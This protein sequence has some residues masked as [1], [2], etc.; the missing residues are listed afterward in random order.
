VCG[1]G[2]PEGTEACD[3]G[4][5]T[6]GD[7]C[8][9][10]CTVTACGNGV[11][12]GTEACDDGNTT[13]G[14]GCDNN[15]TAS[16]CGN[17]ISA[18]TEGCDDGNT[19]NN[20]GCSNT[21][22][23][24]LG[25]SCTGTAPTTCATVCSD[26]L[27]RGA[28]QCD[29][30][31]MM[32]TDGCSATCT[33]EQGYV[34]TGTPSSCAPTCG[35][36]LKIG[37]E[38]CDDGN[39]NSND[40]C[41]NTC[42]LELGFSCT[43][44]A[45]TICDTVCSDGLI[46][47]AEQCDDGNVIATDG[48]SATCTTEP[49]FTCTGTPSICSTTCGDGV[50]AGAEACDDAPPAENGDGCSAIC[51]VE[52]GFTC[53][54]TAP[55]VC[56]ATCGDGVIAGGEACDDAP[57]AE[58]GD[59]CSSTC[60]VETGFTCTG[61]PSTCLSSCGD[62]LVASDE[63][64]DDAPPAEN[65]DGCSSICSVEFGFTCTGTPSS[66]A[67][68]CGDGLKASTEACDDA[69]PA[70]DGDGCSATCT[71]EAGWACS[72]QMPSVCFR[73]GNGITETG[74]E[75]DDGNT[76]AG[77]GCHQCRFDLGCASGQQQVVA[78]NSSPL[79][80]PDNNATGVRSPVTVTAT[81]AVKKAGVFFRRITHTYDADLDISL[82]NAASVRRD[83]TSDNGTSVANFIGT[84]FDDGAT[85]SITSG[86][87][88]YTGRFRPEQTLNGT[89]GSDYLDK[90]AAGTWNLFLVDDANGDTGTLNGWSLVLC[91]DPA[92]FCG[93]GIVN[94]T[95][96]CD[97]AT[98]PL[99]DPNVCRLRCGNG[100]V[101]NLEECDD[102]NRTNGDGCS[103]ACQLEFSCP[104]GQTAV[105][106]RNNSSV[107]ITDNNLVGVTSPISSTVSGAVTRVGVGLSISH[108]S[109]SDLDIYLTGPGAALERE[110]STDNGGTGD[111]Y[112]GTVF[113]D[114]ATTLVTSGSAPFSGTF[115]PELSLSSTFGADFTSLQAQGTWTL[116]VADDTAT[117]TGTIDRWTLMLCVDPNAPVCGDG[118]RNGAEECDDGNSSNTDACTNTCQLVDGC[119]D[120]NLDAGEQCD[121]NN[122]VS[123][124]G[125]SATCQYD[126]TCPSGQQ[127]VV[128]S[129]TSGLAIPDNVPAGG[130]NNQVA[131]SV[132][133]AVTKVHVGLNVSH[134]SDQDLDIY[135][136]G[137]NTIQREL[138]SD[139]G[140]TGDNYFGTAFLD[141]APTLVTAGV[142]PFTGSFRPE[143]S[144]TTT[145]GSDFLGS[146]AAG[147]WN[148]RVADDATGEIGT[149]N[150]WTLLL[151]V[152]T[153]AS[154]CGD[155]I[156][157]A[158]E[159]CDDANTN[160]ADACSN[161][162]QIVDGCG[163]GNIDSGELCDDNNIVGGDGCSVTCQP[164][165]T[166]GAGETAVVV[167]N[168]TSASVPDTVGGLI[169]TINVPVAGLVRKVIPRLNVTHANLTHLDLRLM[170]PRGGSRE[171]ATD[172]SGANYT[173][174]LFSDAA[175]T[176]VTSGSVHRYV[177]G[178][179]D[180]V[181][182]SGLRQPTG[183]GRVGA[184][185]ERRHRGHHRYVELVGPRAVRRHLGGDV[186]RQWHL[187]VGRDVRRRQ[188]HGGR[189][190]QRHLPDRAHL[191]RGPA[192]D[193]HLDRRPAPL[194]GCQHHRRHQHHQRHHDGDGA[195]GGA[196]HRQHRSPVRR[197]SRR[198]PD[199]ADEHQPGHH[200]GQWQQW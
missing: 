66:C 85:T 188:H 19:T 93:D 65:G 64:C 115:R 176:A 110:L 113:F 87:A 186:V 62:G 168:T 58:N 49:G 180:A 196:V 53:T 73:C 179:A 135:L 126:I 167:S 16:A 109:D 69:A 163:D 164:D 99:C 103:S 79:S 47:G 193:H 132:T 131:V 74:E 36:G 151:C 190:L 157:G 130:A 70:E 61:A 46:R 40:G 18:G 177:P 189:R 124:D 43:G 10:N 174:T 118:T 154:F 183:G 181:R 67:A 2:T 28:E 98:D 76:V 37:T 173:S 114:S 152:D 35:D 75:C 140:S 81:G 112:R 159:E 44:S 34:C 122:I 185:R 21:C 166:C 117:T 165:I 142:A 11:P 29:D 182:L 33:T 90:A 72:G 171:L 187:G 83:L 27:V 133:G 105:L 14:D 17:A 68:T 26:G 100:V 155:G 129:G 111:H 148:L 95:E 23:V 172:L 128:V 6:N 191:H 84:F 120:G 200:L 138:S 161:F 134:T 136:T 39:P 4:N 41:S 158:N 101:E 104:T 141:S 97:S 80:I 170:S 48:C 9:N 60:T 7:G 91:V 139:N 145:L 5:T 3:D 24:E 199:L 56:S 63:A 89:L 52:T 102:T 22:V 20:D 144:L 51:T 55:S 71:V 153:A 197:R 78:T 146:R 150:Q 38:A 162:C 86:T 96:E 194:P 108:L 45:P 169:S 8:D 59:G 1:N 32:G 12:A 198:H 195:E 123:G 143:Q 160:G 116:R 82:E 77:D 57:P 50:R 125:C 178:A 30:G 42:T 94:G 127:T 156:V 92:G 106:L 31:N 175:A 149:F 54:G 107:A 184:P 137:P 119:G 13:N 15:C 192:G 147:N 25:F 88:P 121:D